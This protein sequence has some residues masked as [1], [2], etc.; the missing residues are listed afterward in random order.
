M[1]LSHAPSLLLATFAAGA[2]ENE[3]PAL[4]IAGSIS[5][6]GKLTIPELQAL[7]TGDAGLERAPRTHRVTGGLIPR[8]P[9]RDLP[10]V[11]QMLKRLPPLGLPLD[12]PVAAVAESSHAGQ[13]DRSR[14]RAGAELHALGSTLGPYCGPP[15]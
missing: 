1:K 4:E 9:A 15:S 2:E 12:C 3:L 6:P 8:P 7:R 5:G 10:S 13:Q 14:Q 11:K